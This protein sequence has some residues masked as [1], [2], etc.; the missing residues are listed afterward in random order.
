MKCQG[1]GKESIDVKR[2]R[3]NTLYVDNE[4]NYVNLCKDC[5]Q[6]NDEYW[7]ERWNDYY[8]GCLS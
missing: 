7:T 3:Q 8:N 1:C 5:Q 6:E 2:R 4:M